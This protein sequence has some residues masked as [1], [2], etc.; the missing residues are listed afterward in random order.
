MRDP[1]SQFPDRGLAERL[2]RDGYAVVEDLLTPADVER[3]LEIFRSLDCPAQHG[4]WSASMFSSDPGYRVAVDRAI[5]DVLVARAATLLPGYR[6]R[7]CNFLVKEPQVTAGGVVQIHQDPTFVDEERYWSLGIWAPLVDTDESNGGIA[8]LPG[9][10]R[11]NDGPRS[12]GGWSPYAS[13]TARMLQ[14]A[15]PVRIR[16]GSALVF[17]QKLFHGSPPNRSR[18]TR[19]SAASLLVSEGA[20]LRCYYANPALPQHLEVFEVDDAFYTR[21]AYAT[22]PEG[23]PRLALV[24]RFF[25]PIGEEQLAA[26]RRRDDVVRQ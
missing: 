3:L 25:T 26:S 5:S 6:S 20:P 23:V 22:R 8:V 9:S 19:V 15:L 16:A 1:Y 12:F 14:E 4:E 13:M 11:W 7:T 2:H 10:H 21:Y 24:D 18:A 17:S